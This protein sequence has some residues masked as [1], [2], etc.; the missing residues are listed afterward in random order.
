MSEI[1][2]TQASPPP[3]PGRRDGRTLARYATAAGIVLVIA[4]LFIARETGGGSSEAE[5]GM[6]LL[7]EAAVEVGQPAPDFELR[8][9]DGG[10]ARLS[11][12]QGQAVVLNFWATWCPPCRTEMPEFEAIY[13]ERQAGDLVVLAVDDLATDSEAEVRDFIAGLG[14]TFPVLFDTGS[15]AVAQRYGVIGRPSTFFIDAEGVLRARNLG[16][17]TTVII[18]ERVA[19]LA[20]TVAE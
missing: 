12:Y 10:T 8:T 19:E 15:S 9:L 17:V 3:T 18:A 14:V 11:D 16:P 6:G 20:S 13:R 7:D 1:A 4:A 2:P 5:S